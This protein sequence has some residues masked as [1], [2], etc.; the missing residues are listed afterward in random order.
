MSQL[1]VWITN[2]TKHILIIDGTGPG[3]TS[4]YPL[5]Q[6]KWI[7][8][9]SDDVKNLNITSDANQELLRGSL[10]FGMSVGVIVDKGP[11]LDTTINMIADINGTRWYEVPDGGTITLSTPQDL[12]PDSHIFLVVY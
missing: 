3:N 2:N 4:V 6:T 11:V 5:S 7:S 12:Q 9:D 1:T 10:T 8:E